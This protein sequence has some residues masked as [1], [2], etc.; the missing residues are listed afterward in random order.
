LPVS[1]EKIVE[2]KTLSNLRTLHCP[3]IHALFYVFRIDRWIIQKKKSFMT[4][5]HNT[6]GKFGKTK[7]IMDK[8]AKKTIWLCMHI[9]YSPLLRS[10]NPEPH[11]FS[12][13]GAGVVI[14]MI[15]LRFKTGVHTVWKKCRLILRNSVQ[16]I[17][18]L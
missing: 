4:T 3:L 16:S 17:A 12:F 14:K 18:Y 8:H 15:R 5:V 7:S 13:P 11:H 9:R 1:L 10:R 2:N 6:S